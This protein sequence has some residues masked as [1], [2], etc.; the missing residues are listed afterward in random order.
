M[1]RTLVQSIERLAARLDLAESPPAGLRK[2]V[3]A[4]DS[5]ESCATIMQRLVAAGLEGR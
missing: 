3:A 5:V 1:R 2:S 4:I